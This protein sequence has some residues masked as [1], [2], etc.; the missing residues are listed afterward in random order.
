MIDMDELHL[1]TEALKQA[2]QLHQVKIQNGYSAT[3]DDT[4]LAD[5]KKF[6]EFLRG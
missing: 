5:A 2:V 4:V 1:R 3:N 6:E